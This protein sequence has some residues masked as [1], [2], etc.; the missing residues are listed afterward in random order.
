M[1]VKSTYIIS[2]LNHLR[3]LYETE[4]GHYFLTTTSPT[5]QLGNPLQE[6]R[7]EVALEILAINIFSPKNKQ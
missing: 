6:I 1:K 7:K 4:S 3:I 5:D 2:Y